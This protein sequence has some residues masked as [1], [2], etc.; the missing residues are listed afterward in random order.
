MIETLEIGS[1]LVCV[2]CFGLWAIGERMRRRECGASLGVDHDTYGD[3]VYENPDHFIAFCDVRLCVDATWHDIAGELYH[4][5]SM[6]FKPS[7][8][9]S[10][11]SNYGY[12]AQCV[13]RRYNTFLMA[14]RI[15]AQGADAVPGGVL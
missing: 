15:K 2:M 8:M 7:K 10:F 9:K 4:H 5:D 3:I 12:S 13:K 14:K 6:V 11:L 1:L